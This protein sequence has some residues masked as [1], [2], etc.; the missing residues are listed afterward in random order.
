MSYFVEVLKRFLIAIFVIFV[1][2]VAGTFTW[3]IGTVAIIKLVNAVLGYSAV[4]T[5]MTGLSGALVMT[6]CA[7]TGFF[8]AT[9][10]MIKRLQEIEQS[11]GG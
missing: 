7:A 5:L 3:L 9:N 2:A 1:G 10:W 8:F 11:E 6:A 4:Q